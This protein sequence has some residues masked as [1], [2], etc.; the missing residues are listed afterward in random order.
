L[1]ARDPGRRETT[2]KVLNKDRRSPR[3]RRSLR[4]RRGDD[5]HD[6]DASVV[7]VRAASVEEAIVAFGRTRGGARL[8]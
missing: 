6:D 3:E 1:K 7:A 4:T 2:A 5:A 8:E